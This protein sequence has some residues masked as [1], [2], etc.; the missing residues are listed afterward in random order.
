MGLKFEFE[1]FEIVQIYK[2]FPA[3]KF[4]KGISFIIFDFLSSEHFTREFP[5]KSFIRGFLL[6]IGPNEFI[7]DFLHK[8]Y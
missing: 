6:E 5:S 8:I 4:Y 7:R 3:K 2:R 1:F